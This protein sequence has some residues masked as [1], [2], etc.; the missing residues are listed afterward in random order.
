MILSL[1][2]NSGHLVKNQSEVLWYVSPFQPN[3]SLVVHK[4]EEHIILFDMTHKQLLFLMAQRKIKINMLN[5]T[6]ACHV[7]QQIGSHFIFISGIFEHVF[8]NVL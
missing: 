5:F 1:L 7:E 4:Y 8:H 6:I 2:R 3:P